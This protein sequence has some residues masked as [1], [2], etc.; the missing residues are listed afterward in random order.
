MIYIGSVITAED[1]DGYD[2]LDMQVDRDGECTQNFDG[3]PFGKQ[4]L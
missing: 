2:K 1:L 3:E 4:Q